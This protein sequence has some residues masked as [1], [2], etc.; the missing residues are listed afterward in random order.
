VPKPE[1]MYKTGIAFTYFLPKESVGNDVINMSVTSLL[2]TTPSTSGGV[3]CRP[4]PTLKADILN[5]T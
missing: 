4:M 2:W 5:I 1:K 3:V